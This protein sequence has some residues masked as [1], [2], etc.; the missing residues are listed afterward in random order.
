MVNVH[1]PVVA[2]GAFADLIV[3]AGCNSF[4][5]SIEW[6]RLF[7]QR[8]KLCQEAV[9]RYNEIFDCLDK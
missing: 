4:R 6:S 1:W 2:H 9:T 8:G 7:P 3:L 5:L